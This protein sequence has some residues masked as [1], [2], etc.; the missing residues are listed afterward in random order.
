[1]ATQTGETLYHLLLN[2]VLREK[3]FDALVTTFSGIVGSPVFLL[4]REFNLLAY[5]D[6]STIHLCKE[7]KDRLLKDHIDIYEQATMVELDHE[8]CLSCF[9]QPI[10]VDSAIYG[11][12]CILDD[13]RKL[14][15]MD[16]TAMEQAALVM[17]LDFQKRMAV[18]EIE[19]R[20]LN[21]FV[22][23]LL[24]GRM[25]SRSNALHRGTIYKWD[26]T[27]PQVLFVI[28]LVTPLGQGISH[29]SI[30]AK[31][32]YLQK[33]EEV[34]RKAINSHSNRYLVAH[35]GDVNV[36][37]LIPKSETT[38]SIKE[39]SIEVARQLIPHLQKVI[40]SQDM[41]VKIG[42]SRV[43]YDFFELP[44]AFHEAVE[45]IQ[46][47][48]QMDLSNEIVH[49]DDL[50]INRLLLRITDK[51]ELKNY[52]E[53]HLGELIRYDE[54]HKTSLLKTLSVVIET[55]GN[56]KAAANKLFIHYNTLRYRLRKIKELSGID[57]TSWKKVARVVLALQVYHII[58]AREKGKEAR[59]APFVKA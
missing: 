59:W 21:D 11:Y 29:A 5:S 55:D 38:A 58:Q 20:Y 18:E 23:D 30:E 49:Y 25:E 17:A 42:I 14:H 46:M 44:T 50:G 13:P 1:M 57:F 54:E 31:M 51:E 53:E 43:C 19:R 6:E 24:E 16:F 32:H 52:C 36:M 22:R 34:I 2:L 9:L 12:L 27:K 26:L 3:G 8:R 4:D 28:K 56:L 40:E 15:A 48:V 39:E 10:Q 33:L 41:V 47:N 35:L 45:S 7:L 37:L